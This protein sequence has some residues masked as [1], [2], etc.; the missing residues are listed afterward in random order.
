[1]MLRGAP[2]TDALY[3]RTKLRWIANWDLLGL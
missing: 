2:P 1:M 3:Y